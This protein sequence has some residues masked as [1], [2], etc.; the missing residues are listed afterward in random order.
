MFLG[1]DLLIEP[2]AQADTYE[3]SFWEL[4]MGPLDVLMGGPRGPSVNPAEWKK[5]L[6]SAYPAPQML[7]TGDT[8]SIDLVVDPD[9][10]QRLVDYFS[11]QQQRIMPNL[12]RVAAGARSIPTA[13]GVSGSARDFSAE[14]AE[15]RILQPRVSLNGA[16]QDTS[17]FT[18]ALN[19]NGAL[20]WFHQP[21]RGRYILSLAPRQELGFVK[22]GEVRAG[23]ISFTVEGETFT[24][25]SPAAFAAGHAPYFLYV[26]HD[27]GWEPTA[28]AQ[29]GHFQTG[30]V[31][32]EE[33]AQ[34]RRK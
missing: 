6:P 18:G 27:P 20:V 19:A 28:Q 22:A 26:L 2:Q 4:G 17:T 13:P 1:Y 9:T 11:I 30:S 16:A 12:A 14:D 3:V 29:R 34:L 25:E 33:I 5:A 10:G 23:T 15:L 8:V 7:R 21:G 24:L 31:S 32:P